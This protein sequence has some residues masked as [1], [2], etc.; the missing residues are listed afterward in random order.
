M[1]AWLVTSSIPRCHQGLSSCVSDIGLVFS[2]GLLS[3][4]WDQA[5][6]A[7]VT[8]DQRK[9][10]LVIDWVRWMESMDGEWVWK[11]E[12]PFSG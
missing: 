3:P 4:A 8:P 2:R 10:S 5:R 12:G 11:G 6:V 9:D 7:T 1:Q